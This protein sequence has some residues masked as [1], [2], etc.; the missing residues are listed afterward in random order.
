MIPTCWGTEEET[1]SLALTVKP[2]I[3]P[4]TSAGGV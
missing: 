1:R 2:E 4:V 3:D